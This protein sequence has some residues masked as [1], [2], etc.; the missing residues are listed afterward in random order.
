MTGMDKMLD[1]LSGR[2]GV[3]G[4]TL[5]NTI[6]SGN[7]NNLLSQMKP[8]DAAKFKSMM[9]NKNGIEKIVKSQMAKDLMKQMKT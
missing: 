6:Q 9:N 8:S 7:V 2:L 1:M 3:S 5:K 4:D